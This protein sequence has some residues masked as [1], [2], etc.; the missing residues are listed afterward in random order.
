[1]DSSSQPLDPGALAALPLF[2]LPDVVL[3][4]GA[5]LPL[6]VFEPR[7]RELTADVLA[8]RRIMGVARLRP[9]YQ[10][11]YAGRPPIFSVAGA[12]YVVKAEELPDGRYNI[13]L[14]GV[15]RVQLDEELPA[16]RAYRRAR[17]HVL[18]DTRS[19]RPGALPRLRGDLVTLCDRLSMLL[20]DGGL[21]LRELSRGVGSPAAFADM[22]AAALVLDPDDRQALLEA[23]DPAD[24]LET[25]T[26]HVA[27]L[28][29]QMSPT[30]GAPN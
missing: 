22:L 20:G 13:L 29:L 14:R 25:L 5:L 10:A 21:E 30:G 27:Q 18:V 24:R 11:D 6:H 3:F 2:P 16:E 4:P 23:T 28:V 26:A 8:G 19:A 15:A 9:G 12:G 7:Y 1:M 17:A